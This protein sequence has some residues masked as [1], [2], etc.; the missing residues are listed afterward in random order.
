MAAAFAAA[1][2][3]PL[4]AILIAFELTSD[5]ALILPLML[6]CGLATSWP[7]SSSRTRSTST[8]CASAASRST[9][10]RTSTCMQAVSVGEVMTRTHPTIRQEERYPEVRAIFERT[11][12]TASPS[13]TA[14]TAS[15]A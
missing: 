12:S 1:D 13:S 4:T 14:A 3:A 10:R 2:K 8:R 15:S 6:A 9:S 11:G 5:Y 7:A